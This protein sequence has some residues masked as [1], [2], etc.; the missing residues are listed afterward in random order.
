MS[1]L[2]KHFMNYTGKTFFEEFT[3]Q[4]AEFFFFEKRSNGMRMERTTIVN[5]R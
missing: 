2:P 3:V 5:G 1:F 4:N